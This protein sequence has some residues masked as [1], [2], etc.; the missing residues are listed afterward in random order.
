MIDGGIDAARISVLRIEGALDGAEESAE[1]NPA[2]NDYPRTG[3][4]PV[5]ELSSRPEVHGEGAVA[6]ADEGTDQQTISPLN[7]FGTGGPGGQPIVE[8][9]STDHP[10]VN[11]ALKKVGTG[12]GL[13]ALAAGATLAVPGIGLVLGTGVLATAVA[14]MV[15]KSSDE[16][17]KKEGI[18][19]MLVEQGASHEEAVRLSREWQDK[20]TIVRVQDVAAEPVPSMAKT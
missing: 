6:T 5:P 1:L 3:D 12:I 16:Q 10:A 9:A 11:S 8:K 13:G 4:D 19:G 17:S 20:W 7:T 18:E 15:K 2:Q 14:A